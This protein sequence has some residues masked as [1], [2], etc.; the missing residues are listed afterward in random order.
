MDYARTCTGLVVTGYMA[1]VGGQD[2]R[3][4]D[5]RFCPCPKGGFMK[6]AKDGTLRCSGR[7]AGVGLAGFR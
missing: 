1:T 6:K 4:P 5:G 2:V 3:V 7:P